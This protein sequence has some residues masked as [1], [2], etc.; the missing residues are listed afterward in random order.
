VDW[1][2]HRW[3]KKHR[4]YEACLEQDLFGWIVL[5]SWGRKGTR[6]G[7]SMEVRPESYDKGLEMLEAVRKRRKSRGYELVTQSK[8]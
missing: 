6:S 2:K 4:Y 8:L 5:R 1:L 7:R 3:E